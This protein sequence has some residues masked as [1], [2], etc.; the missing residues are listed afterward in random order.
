MNDENYNT[1][2]LLNSSIILA[3]FMENKQIFFNQRN[4]VS[5]PKN[6][7]KILHNCNT[8]EGSSGGPIVLVDNFR[9]IGIHKEYD[10][11]N[12]KNVG[13]LFRNIIADIRSKDSLNLHIKN[14]IKLNNHPNEEAWDL[15]TPKIIKAANL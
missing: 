10:K 11:K 8:V 12:N 9:V 5:I 14:E 13:N 2:K 7:G 6:N 3:A 15:L 1:K 4:I